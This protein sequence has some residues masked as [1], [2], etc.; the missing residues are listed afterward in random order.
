M[1]VR[2]GLLSLVV[3]KLARFVICHLLALKK[4]GFDPVSHSHRNL[5]IRADVKYSGFAEGHETIEHVRYML[6]GDGPPIL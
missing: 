5:V 1:I 4:R 3:E 6:T 2:Q